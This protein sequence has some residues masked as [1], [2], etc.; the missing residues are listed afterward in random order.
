MQALTKTLF[1]IIII[2]ISSSSWGSMSNVGIWCENKKGNQSEPGKGFFFFDSIK[3]G[4]FNLELKDNNE[5][6]LKYSDLS[7]YIPDKNSPSWTTIEIDKNLKRFVKFEYVFQK[8]N[9]VL[10][11]HKDTSKNISNH[12]CN[13]YYGWSR[14]LDE[15]KQKQNW[16]SKQ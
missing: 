4:L 14:F 12:D 1:I 2:S 9:L 11:F 5:F 13:I 3:V 10:N 15:A 8:D 7:S 16:S 6:L